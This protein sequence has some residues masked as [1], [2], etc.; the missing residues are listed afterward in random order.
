MILLGID[1]NDSPKATAAF[2]LLLRVSHCIPLLD[3]S[4]SRIDNELDSQAKQ[5]SAMFLEWSL[6]LQDQLFTYYS[7]LD[8]REKKPGNAEALLS[9]LSNSAV[10]GFYHQQS[11]ESLGLLLKKMLSQVTSSVVENAAQE[12][13]ALV[14][15]PG[16]ASPALAASVLVPG[17]LSKIVSTKNGESSLRSVADSQLKW[18]YR[19]LGAAVTGLGA[20]LLPYKQDLL[21]AIRLG[22]EN[23]GSVA[24]LAG[25]LLKS[26]LLSLTTNY[27]QERRS[28]PPKSWTS[29]AFQHWG[30][31][32]ANYESAAISWHVPNSDEL[33]FAAE[34]I[35]AIAPGALEKTRAG[36]EGSDREALSAVFSTIRHLV[37]GSFAVLPDFVPETR[38]AE[39][40]GWYPIRP[41]PLTFTTATPL[42]QFSSLKSDLIAALL[43]LA[44]WLSGN[45]PDEAQLMCD[46]IKTL[47]TLL[48]PKSEQDNASF[49]WALRLKWKVPVPGEV[50]ELRIQKA[51]LL[52]HN[53]QKWS[54]Q[55]AVLAQPVRDVTELFFRLA[56]ADYPTVRTSA[57]SHLSKAVKNYPMLAGSILTRLIENL[58]KKDLSRSA[59]KG[60][61]HTLNTT[62]FMRKITDSIAH[63]CN[64]VL[65][66]AESHTVLGSLFAEQPK[67]QFG[68]HRLFTSFALSF[69]YRAPITNQ[70]SLSHVSPEIGKQALETWR[71]D[72]E[73]NS[74]LIQQTIDR[75]LAQLVAASHWKVQALILTAVTF[76]TDCKSSPHVGQVESAL[77]PLLGSEIPGLRQFAQRF[78]TLAWSWRFKRLSGES[79]KTYRPR[80]STT[81]AWP[82]YGPVEI[83]NLDKIWT[84]T[85]NAHDP[86]LPSEAELART[87]N[88][89]AQAGQGEGSI[90]ILAGSFVFSRR[91]HPTLPRVDVGSFLPSLFRFFRSAVTALRTVPAAWREAVDKAVQAG[92]DLEQ[93]LLAA[94]LLA[95]AT[96]ASK[97]FPDWDRDWLAASW[98]QGLT[99]ASPD[100][101]KAWTAA[102][103]FSL[104]TSGPELDW[105]RQLLVDIAYTGGSPLLRSN[106]AEFLEML[107]LETVDPTLGLPWIAK[108]A[109]LAAQHLDDEYKQV[110]RH[111]GQLLA[112]CVVRLTRL[113]VQLSALPL[114]ALL[115]AD[116]TPQI[117]PALLSFLALVSSQGA[118]NS[119]VGPWGTLAT[120]SLFAYQVNE[121]P[122]ISA[123][124]RS[125]LALLAQSRFDSSSID[126]LLPVVASLGQSPVW[127]TRRAV[128]P[129]LQLL[130]F[131]HSFVL[132]Q[133][134]TD[135]LFALTTH[136]LQD[137]QAE[138]R[139]TGLSALSSLLRTFPHRDLKELIR[140]ATEQA[141]AALPARTSA[142]F[143]TA[144]QHR[145]VGVLTLAAVVAAHP[146]DVPPL[147]PSVCEELCRHGKDPSPVRE[148]VMKA[149]SEFWRTHQDEWQTS[150]KTLFTEDQLQVLATVTS[151]HLTYIS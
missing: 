83:P 96:R 103:R 27:V 2:K 4:S 51:E 35:S 12:Y 20:A 50:R 137:N 24:K 135:Q 38:P 10:R 16:F 74:R 31:L 146:Y 128:L 44:T 121:D 8:K 86:N 18:L 34:L 9:K 109:A 48:R 46:L 33:S 45:R 5:L 88:M 82:S 37:S 22:L 6:R 85:A 47:S 76:L 124:A 81:P 100:T 52:H 119:I 78:L 32:S 62:Y 15:A 68:L 113:N 134:Q 116:N 77:I 130:A 95:G 105:L 21:L 126:L 110:S 19:M 102:L 54:N 67:L 115:E 64:F 98:R 73:S 151:S 90:Q 101:L 148:T 147:L 87:F 125:T 111:S 80:S 70:P 145:H 72:N 118:V 91:Q 94:E 29:E 107:V 106:E 149:M 99:Q 42:A 43:N 143:A 122:D 63:T 39:N 49:V 79:L 26:V 129:F 14:R 36:L 66:I 132:S 23:S 30:E 144:V 112:Q 131:G 17:I 11:E 84:V 104:G 53:R 65:R 127:H 75:L 138:V 28:L 59:L 41:Q 139:E 56:V 69:S 92:S 58:G 13:D 150:F 142:D 25:K 108:A 40:R 89:Q 71:S 117:V 57:Q 61:I 93:S 60:T 140:T 55:V 136:R 7:H 114:P 141:R 120:R 97:R 3:S 123:S 1:P 133:S